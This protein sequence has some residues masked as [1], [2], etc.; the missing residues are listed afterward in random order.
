MRVIK[1]KRAKCER[2]SSSEG[3]DDGGASRIYSSAGADVVVFARL[4]GST[5]QHIQ[6]CLKPTKTAQEHHDRPLPGSTPP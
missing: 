2:S 5:I 6:L 3:R 4:D 1:I